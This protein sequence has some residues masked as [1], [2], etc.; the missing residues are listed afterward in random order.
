MCKC[1][2][3]N[4]NLFCYRSPECVYPQVDPLEQAINELVTS[5]GKTEA[6]NKLL[7]EAE[8]LIE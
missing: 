4:K 2:P 5:L 3:N 8:K 7:A 1:D 6:R